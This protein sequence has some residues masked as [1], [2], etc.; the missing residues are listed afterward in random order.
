[1]IAS[2]IANAHTGCLAV[3]SRPYQ[4]QVVTSSLSLTGTQRYDS[5]G[6]RVVEVSND[7]DT[8]FEEI[9]DPSHPDAVDGVVR[10]PNVNA[11]KEMADLITLRLTKEPQGSKASCEWPAR[12]PHR[13]LSHHKET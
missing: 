3:K 13:P 8:P 5:H 1:M 7:N 10:Y 6:V 11:T 2:N 9:N 4:R 12:P